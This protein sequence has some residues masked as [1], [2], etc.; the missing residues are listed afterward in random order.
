MIVW[1]VGVLAMPQQLAAGAVASPGEAAASTNVHDDRPAPGSEKIALDAKGAALETYVDAYCSDSGR[2]VLVTL[3][4]GPSDDHHNAGGPRMDGSA[5]L[6][7]ED[8]AWELFLLDVKDAYFGCVW[9]PGDNLAVADC[10][11]YRDGHSN[12]R[13]SHGQMDRCGGND[14]AAYRICSRNRSSGS[15]SDDCIER[16]IERLQ[17]NG[18]PQ[19]RGCE[20]ENE[21]VTIRHQGAEVSAREALATLSTLGKPLPAGLVLAYVPSA[22]ANNPSALVAQLNATGMIREHEAV[23]AADTPVL[24]LEL[25]KGAWEF[26]PEEPRFAG[27]AKLD[28]LGDFFLRSP[29]PARPKPVCLGWSWWLELAVV[30]ASL[31]AVGV[32]GAITLRCSR[33]QR[34][35]PQSDHT[36]HHMQAHSQP[37]QS[38]TRTV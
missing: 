37:R 3:D 28:A 18:C 35:H 23:F 16:M 32:A 21:I 2:G 15:G 31:A 9:H 11:Y 1:L 22:F 26:P 27:T 10:C 14:K 29:R 20:F 36:V 12:Q 30:A 24:I 7:R 5:T 38:R 34:S 6:L 13:R 19:A 25:A 33:L 17:D 8:A 4:L